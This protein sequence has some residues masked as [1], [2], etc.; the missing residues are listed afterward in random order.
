MAL[1]LTSV[2]RWTARV[3]GILILLTIVALAIGEGGPNP[4]RISLRENLL[5]L[6]L[7]PMIGGIVVGWKWE[8]IGGLLILGG[9]AFFAIV[10][11]RLS[12]NVVTVPWLLAGLL[13]LG[14]G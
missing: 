8:G 11:H 10:N 5:G 7:L 1:L 2:L 14:C 6:G 4:F 3:I 12:L 13:Y 9:F